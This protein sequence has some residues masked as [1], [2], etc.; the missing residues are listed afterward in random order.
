MYSQMLSHKSLQM[1]KFTYV[2]RT[3]CMKMPVQSQAG[4]WSLNL[5]LSKAIFGRGEGRVVKLFPAYNTGG[6]KF[7]ILAP[8]FKG[9]ALCEVSLQ[10][11]L[12]SSSVF[13]H[14]CVKVS[15][16]MH[17]LAS[18]WKHMAVNYDTFPFTLCP[19]LP[20]NT[21]VFNISFK[22]MNSFCIY[23]WWSSRTVL[24]LNWSERR[25]LKMKP[26]LP[27]KYIAFHSFVPL[28]PSRSKVSGFVYCPVVHKQCRMSLDFLL[29][30]LVLCVCSHYLSHLIRCTSNFQCNTFFC[31]AFPVNAKMNSPGCNDIMDN[32]RKDLGRWRH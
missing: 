17:A 7:I 13:W 24:D 5:E 25:N 2:S 12:C 15:A 21:E 20:T 22:Y 28:R 3:W 1:A 9:S 6:P 18:I 23:C 26:D 29:M 4:V 16:G 31:K 10:R 32:I 8:D 14:W 11:S 30:C 27:H 19:R